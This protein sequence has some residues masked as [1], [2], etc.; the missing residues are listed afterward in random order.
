MLEAGDSRARRATMAAQE[1]A[2][3]AAPGPR[4]QIGLID[5]SARKNEQVIE[6]LSKP[7]Q[8]LREA[9]INHFKSNK[10]KAF[11]AEQVEHVNAARQ[12]G[13]GIRFLF[14]RDNQPPANMPLEEVVAERKRIENHIA[15]L[16]AICAEL[17][18]SLV[19]IKQIEDAALDLLETEG[20]D[21]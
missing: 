5:T 20:S 7:Q 11:I 1:E 3:N 14:D 10:L 8:A 16:E 6:R 4:K 19:R 17:K 12:I 21:G 2:G 13:E 15:W 9:A 18:N